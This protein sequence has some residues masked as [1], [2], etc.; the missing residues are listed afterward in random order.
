VRLAPSDRP[1]P[2]API[3]NVQGEVGQVTARPSATGHVVLDGAIQVE[4]EWV[5]HLGRRRVSDWSEPWTHLLSVPGV[6]EGEVLGVAANLVDLRWAPDRPLWALI[7]VQVARYRPVAVPVGWTSPP[8]G[9]LPPLAPLPVLVGLE[10]A[11]FE[12]EGAPPVTLGAGRMPTGRAA[13]AQPALL[14]FDQPIRRLLDLTLRPTAG[15]TLMADLLVAP[16]GGGLYLLEALVPWAAVP[17]GVTAYPTTGGV[18]L[19]P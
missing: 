4:V 2:G 19:V 8:G 13:T 14:P 1:S 6:E 18:A 16:A 9:G 3:R 5:D 10:G 15:R 17:P 7:Q 11:Q 12:W